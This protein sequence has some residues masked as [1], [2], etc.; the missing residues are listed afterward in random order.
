MDSS[1]EIIEENRF[2]SMFHP[3]DKSFGSV[4]SEKKV[5]TF[6]FCVPIVCDNSW[7]TLSGVKLPPFSI[8]YSIFYSVVNNATL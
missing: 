3:M 5:I 7:K 1:D 2:L 4:L 6:F 8:F